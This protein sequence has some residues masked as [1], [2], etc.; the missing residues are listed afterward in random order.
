MLCGRRKHRTATHAG[1]NSNSTSYRYRMYSYSGRLYQG[2]GLIRALFVAQG[3]L[4]LDKTRRGYRLLEIG[5]GRLKNTARFVLV[6]RQTPSRKAVGRPAGHGIFQRFHG[7]LLRRIAKKAKRKAQSLAVLFHL[8]LVHHRVVG[9]H[10]GATACNAHRITQNLR[11][12]NQ[13][14]V[15]GVLFSLVLGCI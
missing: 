8:Q 9:G 2:A 14:N 13:Q 11:S 15:F 1:C 7:F 6:S 5:L 10:A 3:G 12:F 4:F